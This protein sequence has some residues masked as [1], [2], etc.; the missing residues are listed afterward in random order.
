MLGRSITLKIMKRDPSAPVEPSKVWIFYHPSRVLADV[1][2]RRLFEQFLGHGPCEHYNK[3]MPLNAG[4]ATANDG[5]IGDHAWRMLKSFNFDPKELRGI[6]IQIQKLES[7]TASNDVGPGQAYLP[8]HPVVTAV[9]SSSK[10]VQQ[11]RLVIQPPSQEELQNA[12]NTISKPNTNDPLD[13]PSFSQVDQSVFDSLPP[14]IRQELEH[15]Y[16]LRS[17]SPMLANETSALA[18]LA[19]KPPVFP[20]PRPSNAPQLFPNL[21]A[22]PTNYS[23]ITKQ[24]A[25]SNR[26]TVSATKNFLNFGR[27][28]PVRKVRISDAKLLDLDLDPEVFA[29]LPEKIQREQLVRARLLKTHGALP[30]LPTQ[31]KTLKAKKPQYPV[32][33][34]PYRAPA[35]VARFK[36][37]PIMRQQGKAKNERLC[38]T[39]TS[40]IQG[41]VDGWVK[42]FR[43][44]PP[45]EQ[46]L[47]F[48]SKYLLTAVDHAE[49]TDVHLERA[50]AVMKWWLV[51]LRR[52]WGASELVDDEL[53]GSQVDPVGRAWWA[54]F[55][56]IKEQ[57]DVIARKR[58]G[59]SLSLR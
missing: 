44:W 15:E 22:K 58:F 29:A 14:D 59:G 12:G 46:D 4:R 30:D 23:R 25:P 10:A 2:V 49:G 11:P 48:F 38:F 45:K 51:L 19:I 37:A 24:L 39:E 8:F 13:L 52:Y 3:Q 18:P 17:T 7:N 35:P 41:I 1:N 53:D 31:R 32:G 27:K 33:W 54:A 6:G 40:D 21:N 16:K 26:P 50:V 34:V 55:R 42:R 28:P 56:E 5:V 9:A 57:M 20:K 47:G 36:P 43:Y